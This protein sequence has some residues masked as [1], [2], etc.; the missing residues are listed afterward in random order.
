MA[1]GRFCRDPLQP[2]NG[3]VIKKNPILDLGIFGTAPF[4]SILKFD[5]RALIHFIKRFEKFFFFFWELLSIFY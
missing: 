2:A 1:L 5:F 4:N 3:V